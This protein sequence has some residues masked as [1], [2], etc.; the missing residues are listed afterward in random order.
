MWKIPYSEN[1]HY[2]SFSRFVW[3]ISKLPDIHQIIHE[4]Y[5]LKM[6][7]YSNAFA[8]FYFELNHNL[9]KNFKNSLIRINSDGKSA[10]IPK[11]VYI[12][13]KKTWHIFHNELW[14]FCLLEVG[15]STSISLSLSSLEVLLLSSF[16]FP[17]G[18]HK[19]S[20]L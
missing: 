10:K 2:N 14:N 1:T 5:L 12:L 7:I 4:L 18:S 6:F 8:W 11:R 9:K 16:S 15:N 20:S 3:I 17:I 19:V 13:I